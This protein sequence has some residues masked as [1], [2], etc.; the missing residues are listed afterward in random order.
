MD[1]DDTLRCILL[2]CPAERFVHR[3]VCRAWA[4]APPAR[5]TADAVA[6]SIERLKVALSCGIRLPW[7]DVAVAAARAG[8]GE[9]ALCGRPGSSDQQVEVIAAAIAGG[10]WPLV[11]E[12]VA[13]GYQPSDHQNVEL[14]YGGRRELA[15]GTPEWAELVCGYAISVLPP[16]SDFIALH[17]AFATCSGC[18]CVDTTYRST[19]TSRDG[20]EW[21]ARLGF[22]GQEA[23]GHFRPIGSP[24]T[25]ELVV[26]GWAIPVDDMVIPVRA[27]Y[28]VSVYLEMRFDVRPSEWGVTLT[29]WW[30]PKDLLKRTQEPMTLGPLLA[31]YG[32][33]GDVCGVCKRHDPVKCTDRL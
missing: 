6:G 14:R 28:A 18:I 23:V 22:S 12:L 3:L 29:K 30:L 17:M 31:R 15:R 2:A 20:D 33:C 11:A 19:V 25:V 8:C 7:R 10:H 27:L 16:E 5:P 13:A 24:R 9:V 21:V 26:H 32:M 1:D 4:Q